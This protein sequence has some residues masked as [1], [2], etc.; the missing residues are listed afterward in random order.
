MEVPKDDLELVH[1]VLDRVTKVVASHS[2][3]K[4]EGQLAPSVASPAPPDYDAVLDTLDGLLRR[5]GIAVAALS[6]ED[7]I[8]LVHLLASVVVATQDGPS[9]KLAPTR[10]SFYEAHI[11]SLAEVEISQLRELC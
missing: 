6:R 1:A 2:D 4:A 5:R 10:L 7:R 3:S 9:A 8:K 11:V